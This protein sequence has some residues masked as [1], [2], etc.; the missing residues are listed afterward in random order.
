MSTLTMWRTSRAAIALLLLPA[1]ATC[2]D[3]PTAPRPVA[4]RHEF[5]FVPDLP[6]GDESM[7]LAMLDGTDSTMRLVIRLP[8]AV[9]ATAL[10]WELDV[11]GSGATLE[12]LLP[13]DL[14]AN[15][16]GA[17]AEQVG[18][19]EGRH[20]FGVVSLDSY[21][22]ERA[23]PGT[24]VVAEFRRDHDQPFTVTVRFDGDATVLYGAGGEPTA[25]R[26]FGGRLVYREVGRGDAT[27]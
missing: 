14:F 24:L 8:R 17:L 23:G 21:D 15:E 11:V 7:H 2:H 20:W 9:A 1:L 16:P 26:V 25:E 3:A 13:G 19:A 6:A 5:A 12:R 18:D 27:R 10:V 4:P 22:R